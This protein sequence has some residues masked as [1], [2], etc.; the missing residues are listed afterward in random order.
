MYVAALTRE[1]APSG[2]WS[3]RVTP[4]SA[5]AP[6]RP[7]HAPGSDSPTPKARRRLRKSTWSTSVDLPDPDTPVMQTSRPSGTSTVTSFRLFSRAPR[8]RR[9]SAVS[10]GRRGAAAARA[11][12]RPERNAPVT[13]RALFSRPATGPSYTTSPPSLPGP[14]PRST[15]WSAEAMRLPSCSTTMTALPASARRRRTPDSFATS[16]GCRPTEGSSSTY[17][18]LVSE[19]PRAVARVT[20]CASPPESV[21]DWRPSVRYPRPTSTRK[22]RR[23]RI[24]WSTCPEAGSFPG[25]G[26]SRKSRSLSAIGFASTSGSV[27]PATRKSRASALSREPPQSAQVP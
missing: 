16:R 14:G 25:T 8:T 9:R 3:T 10:I 18:V 23:P 6:S 1:L 20:R 5:V 26:H 15:T 2:D 11:P 13:E 21:R 4:V 27:H 17:I 22:R 12:A 7:S 19:P 24:S